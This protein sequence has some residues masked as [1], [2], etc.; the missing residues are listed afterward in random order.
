[1]KGLRL[2]K[3]K[4]GVIHI[5]YPIAGNQVSLCRLADN[6]EYLPEYSYPKKKMCKRCMH[7][8]LFLL[9]MCLRGRFTW[10]EVS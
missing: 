2:F 3:T 6:G 7:Q 8:S 5:Q 4:T 1:M 9:D 10:K